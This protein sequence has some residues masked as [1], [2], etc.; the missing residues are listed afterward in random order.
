[1]RKAQNSGCLCKACEIFHLLLCGVIGACT[2]I[3]KLIDRL[4][5]LGAL[6]EDTCSQVD[7]LAQ[8]K[9]VI[10]TP[11]KYD[12]TVKCLKPYLNT[13]KLESSVHTCLDGKACNACGFRKWWSKSLKK[14]NFN[15]D[16]T[17]NPDVALAGEEWILSSID[18]GYF[19]SVT[20]PAIASHAEEVANNEED[21]EYQPT[22]QNTSRKLCQATQRGTLVGF[23]DAFELESEKHAYHRNFF[24]PSG[25][26]KLNTTEMSALS[27]LEGT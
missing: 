27:L 23:L 9:D 7:V 22:T 20:R 13:I 21:A 5:S 17:M 15:A 25:V 4:R 12:T 26:H 16:S 1:M 14:K 2:Y 24:P 6:S 11:S 8:I 19:P 10:A 3:N 18:W